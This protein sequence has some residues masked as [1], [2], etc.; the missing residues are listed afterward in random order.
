MINP[1]GVLVGNYRTSMS[2]ND[3]NRQYLKP[4]QKLHPPVIAIKR[5]MKELR[6]QYQY[7]FP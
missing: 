5:L 1:D 7:N 2:G 4:H 6:S 3:L